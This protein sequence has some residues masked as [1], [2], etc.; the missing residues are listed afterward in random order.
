MGPAFWKRVQPFGVGFQDENFKF[1][2]FTLSLETNLIKFNSSV[3]KLILS[4]L[5][6]FHLGPSLSNYT[7]SNT[8]ISN[9]LS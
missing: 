8:K 9:P 4:S 3:E 7:W 2:V 5:T 1:R 6:K